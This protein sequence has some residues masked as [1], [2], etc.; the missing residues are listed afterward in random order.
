MTNR[1]STPRLLDNPPIPVQAKIA[2]AWTTFMFLYIYVDYFGLYK[3]G[4][5]DD[6]LAGAIFVFDITPT[7]LTIGLVS[8]L[9]PAVMVVLSMTLRARVNRATNLVVA[10]LYS[11]YSM[12]NAAGATWEWAAF[13]GISIG[14][15]VL[16]LAFILRSA[17]A[18]PRATP[19]ATMPTSRE[20][21]GAQQQA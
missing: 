17:W 12:F 20:A 15:E 10:S 8:V 4:T 21:D 11:P 14:V 3:P 5:L 7:F 19:T 2:A 16:I 6:I 13:Y 18:W 9:I 1:T